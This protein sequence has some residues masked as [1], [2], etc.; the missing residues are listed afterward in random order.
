[1]RKSIFSKFR[2]FS[3]KQFVSGKTGIS[4]SLSCSNR[5]GK[6]FV[7]SDKKLS[8]GVA[9]VHLNPIN[10]GVIATNRVTIRFITL[11]G[12]QDRFSNVNSSRFNCGKCK[13]DNVLSTSWIS[14]VSHVDA[15]KSRLRFS[16][17]ISREFS[18]IF[19]V[20]W[21][22]V[23]LETNMSLVLLVLHIQP[24]LISTFNLLG[25][26]MRGYFVFGK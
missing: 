8:L 21:L 18:S 6:F 24:I 16:F 5:R 7:N 4:S 17:S 26:F 22:F 14:V 25:N 11:P 13:F 9:S 1:M 23:S 2:S 15:L 20:E 12:K 19:R 10:F 3:R